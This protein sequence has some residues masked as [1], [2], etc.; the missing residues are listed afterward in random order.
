MTWAFTALAIVW[1]NYA[2]CIARFAEQVMP[3]LQANG[4][5]Q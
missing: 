1:M 3:I 2:E 5:R 4:I